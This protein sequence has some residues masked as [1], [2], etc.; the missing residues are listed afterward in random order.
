MKILCSKVI[1][2]QSNLQK[3]NNLETF[4]P[5]K[6][7]FQVIRRSSSTKIQLRSRN[8]L[9]VSELPSIEAREVIRII[10][11]RKIS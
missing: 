2:L 11:I 7:Q 1:H 9:K 4:S 6:H 3:R 8:R 5:I 10:L